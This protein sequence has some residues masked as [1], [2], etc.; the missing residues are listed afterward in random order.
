MRLKS[1]AAL[2]RREKRAALYT[3]EVGHNEYEQWIGDGGAIYKPDDLP[4]IDADILLTIFDVSGKNREDWDVHSQSWPDWLGDSGAAD[5]TPLETPCEEF[6]VRLVIGSE[7]YMLL[8]AGS[9]F[10]AI[11]TKYLAPLRDEMTT[12]T[13]FMRSFADNGKPYIV[14]KS[15]M[16]LRAVIMPA[17]IA[18]PSLVDEL[19]SAAAELA[20]EMLEREANRENS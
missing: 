8:R 20:D 2:C 1:I 14:A 17:R 9:R 15:G 4:L 6:K 19:S 5:V 18:S 16:L 11:S 10:A 7:E 3:R 13:Y 12:V